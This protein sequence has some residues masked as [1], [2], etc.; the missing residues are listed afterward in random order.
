MKT[1]IFLAATAA[2][3]Q[4][5][6]TRGSAVFAGSCS[7]GYC[8]ASQGVGGGAPRLAARGFTAEFI[9]DTI[10]NGVAGTGMVAFGKT[11]SRADLNAVVAYVASLNGITATGETVAARRRTFTGAAER[12]RVLFSEATR[13]FGRCSTCHQVNGIGI[14]VAPP[15]AR[16]PATT[17]ALKRLATP[18]IATAQ[19][20]GDRMPAAVVARRAQDVAFYDLTTPPPV[21]RTVAAG[22]V[23]VSDGS[24]WSHA[25]VIGGYTDTELAAVL[26]YLRA[27][28]P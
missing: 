26:A 24:A 5:P 17:A 2:L 13:G 9:R 4:T 15:I 27:A 14:A 21:L 25:G 16:V 11:L 12:G 23:Q 7:T 22:D 1:L 19:Y 8:H 18:N 28:V 3:A 6:V 10:T 20:A